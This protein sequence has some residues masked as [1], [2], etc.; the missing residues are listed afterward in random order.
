MREFGLP[1]KFWDR[2]QQQMTLDSRV[3]L[4]AE[5]DSARLVL[6]YPDDW[7]DVVSGPKITTAPDDNWEEFVSEVK[8][9]TRGWGRFT[10]SPMSV[11]MMDKVNGELRE[12]VTAAPESNGECYLTK[13]PGRG[14]PFEVGKQSHPL[15]LRRILHHL[16]TELMPN[17][18][19]GLEFN[20]LVVYGPGGHFA[21]HQDA[22][23]AGV[24][25][26]LLVGLPSAHTGGVLEVKE[27]G[28]PSRMRFDF[29]QAPPASD[30]V[31]WAAF[32][33]DCEHQVEP[34]E[35]GLRAVLC[36]RVLAEKPRQGLESL[37]EK[38]QDLEPLLKYDGLADE[39]ERAHVAQDASR[40]SLMR[41]LVSAAVGNGDS[42]LV[43]FILRHEY[44][45]ADPGLLKG[46]DRTLYQYLQS[47]CK[48]T[49]QPRLYNILV[50]QEL[51]EDLNGA[52][53]DHAKPRKPGVVYALDH[54][55]CGKDAHVRF[56]QAP[57]P[58][59]H[60]TMLSKRHLGSEPDYCD[61][62]PPQYNEYTYAQTAV[63]INLKEDLATP[64]L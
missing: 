33:S 61:G 13:Q 30:A 24:V 5:L 14:P 18:E 2:K 57:Q 59:Q 40:T 42:P 20:K 48:P 19:L 52:C 47:Q 23:V 32:F 37:A 62:M 60:F 50:E 27:P 41:Q 45:S 35:S 31:H 36:Y 64:P 56:V 29:G 49:A 6:D 58:W 7:D 12:W 9:W 25:G 17:M 38:P 46:M 55:D 26:T 22:P 34:V 44:G 4:S 39:L 1:S 3:R 21:A 10:R 53:R 28:G 51:E 43:G 16:Q 15:F 8:R 63:V 54:A 11:A